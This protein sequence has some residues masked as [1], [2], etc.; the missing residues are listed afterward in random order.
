MRRRS[1]DGFWLRSRAGAA[2]SLAGAVVALLS[3]VSTASAEDL[4]D[5]YRLAVENDPQLR[6][7]FSAYQ[8]A[9]QRLPQARAGFLPQVNATLSRNRN[10]EEITTESFIFSRPSGQASYYS[11]F[12]EV[13]LSQTIYSKALWTGLEQA[14][15]EVRRAEAEYGA[16]R[17][18]LILRV[19]EAYFQALLAQ[20]ALALA[21]AER[22]LLARNQETAEGRRQAGSGT[23]IEVYDARAR[24]QESSAAV[25][26]ANNELNDRREAL[27]EL[28]AALP[29]RLRALPESVRLMPPDP[30]DV[31]YWVD[32]ALANNP[33]LQAAKE[34]MAVARLEI[35]RNRAAHWP[36]LEAVGNHSRQDADASIPGPGV[37]AENTL[38]GIQLTIPLYQGGAVT[39]RIEG[40]VHRYEAARQELEARRRNVERST[41]AAFNGVTTSLARVHALD[42]AVLAAESALAAK[43]EGRGFGLYTTLDV[44]D[45]TRDLFRAKNERAEARHA[46]FSELLRLRYAAGALN[47]DDV[48]AINARL[49]P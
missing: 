29:G 32:A 38:V 28:T 5:V 19:T 15:A 49:R 21:D 31:S 3:L 2:F 20:D 42:Q 48:R 40:A 10:D 27:R 23:I 24:L 1:T 46:Y 47:D 11:D 45:T 12:Y 44:L 36:T 33:D 39:A 9:Q 34:S 37:R 14:G 22:D 13:T 7:A 6:G 18:N 35:D 25:I 8:A 41:R 4:L 26:A 16:T 30:A 17:Q 43:T